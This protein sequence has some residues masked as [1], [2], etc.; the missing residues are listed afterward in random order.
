MQSLKK[1]LDKI[2][3]V[4]RNWED[5]QQLF[6]RECLPNLIEALRTKYIELNNILSNK[7][8]QNHTSNLKI[9]TALNHLRFLFEQY[10]TICR[11]KLNEAIP[12]LEEN[13][14]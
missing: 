5:S 8:E 6:H 12:K 10:E 7:D 1:I 11:V 2:Y 13:S 3:F 9:K 14:L 4:L